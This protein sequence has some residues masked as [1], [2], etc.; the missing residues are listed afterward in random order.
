LAKAAS[1]LPEVDD[2]AVIFTRQAVRSPY[3]LE[4]PEW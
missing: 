2:C 3:N 1:A 4:P